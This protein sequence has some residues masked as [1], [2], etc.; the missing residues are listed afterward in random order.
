MKSRPRW[1]SP[2][3]LDASA[4]SDPDGNQLR[5]TWF[6]YPEAGTSA[7][8]QAQVKIDGADTAGAT[9]TPTA[10]AR[11]RFGPPG[12]PRAGTG[13]AHIILAVTDSG[14]PAL[15]SYRRIILAVSA[16]APAAK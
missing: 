7:A 14:S 8:P 5:Y 3:S 1:V 10:A 2:S 4:T 16:P 6:H 9:V 15:T 13:I 12:P 11:G